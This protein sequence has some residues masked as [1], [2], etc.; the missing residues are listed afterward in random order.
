MQINLFSAYIFFSFFF[1]LSIIGMFG[2]RNRHLFSLTSRILCR[3]NST[4][5]TVVFP[6]ENSDLRG[7]GAFRRS[8]TYGSTIEQTYSGVLSFLRRTY[9]RNL[10]NVDVAVTGIPLDL[11]TTF[12][13]GTRFGPKGIREAS[14][15]L[16]ELKSYPGGIDVF[17]DLAVVDYGDC[18]FDPGLPQTIPREIEA[19]A[20][21]IIDQN[22]FLLSLG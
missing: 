3:W 4:K 1:F 21:K 5:S 14:V 11:A 7:D 8:N 12:R 15:Q 10:H 9:T 19:H 18:W 20:K 22:V 16:A 13:P 6:G 17:E 2:L